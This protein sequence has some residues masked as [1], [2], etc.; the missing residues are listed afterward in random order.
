LLG[1]FP[2]RVSAQRRL[3]HRPL[4]AEP[5]ARATAAGGG[6]RPGRARLGQ[7]ERP[8]S[9]LDRVGLMMAGSGNRS[10]AVAT[11]KHAIQRDGSERPLQA[12]IVGMRADVFRTRSVLR[13]IA[14][15]AFYTQTETTCESWSSTS[16]P[17]SR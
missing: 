12:G 1:L 13:I 7:V 9:G 3:A 14:S 8:R 16:T 17:P 5:V 15:G 2:Q 11:H 10:R 4:A 6:C